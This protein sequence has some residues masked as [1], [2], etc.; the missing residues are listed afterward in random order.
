MSYGYRRRRSYG[1]RKRRY[2]PS[3]RPRNGWQTALSYAK[4]GLRVA[5]FVRSL[6]NVEFKQVDNTNQAISMSSSW[7]IVPLTN[8]AIGDTSSNR[9]GNTVLLKNFYLTGMTILGAGSSQ[10]PY[11]NVRM[12]LVNV[13]NSSGQNVNVAQILEDP[14]TI[15]S[16]LNSEMATNAFRVVKDERFVL[17]ADRPSRWVK[18]YERFQH[19]LTFDGNTGTQADLISGHLYLLYCEQNGDP[20]AHVTMN[21]STRFQ[22]IDN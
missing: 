9:D 13:Y 16:P 5:N 19:H 12:M 8:I 3:A 22:F 6:V 2:R 21:Y 15:E 14:S 1:G 10:Y 4:T 7:N 18:F 20:T 17:T 11:N